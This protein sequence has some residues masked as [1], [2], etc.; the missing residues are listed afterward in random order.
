MPRVK[1]KFLGNSQ[2]QAVHQEEH[3][4]VQVCVYLSG[5]SVLIPHYY[6][7]IYLIYNIYIYIGI[8]GFIDYV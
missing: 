8:Y 5:V 1:G 2:E 4:T 3:I 6:I 7:C